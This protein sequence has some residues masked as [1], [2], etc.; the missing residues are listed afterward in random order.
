MARYRDL[1][2]LF[3]WAPA[4]AISNASCVSPLARGPPHARLA[5]IISSL[6]IYCPTKVTRQ[7]QQTFPFRAWGGARRR[8]ARKRD[9]RTGM[10]HRARPEHK[11]HHPVHVTLR[12]VRRLASMR[13]QIVFLE[14]RKAI[15]RTARAWFRIVHF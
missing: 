14:V 15:S 11:K 8:T 7:A 3:A 9:P 13:K 4:L 1:F 2:G 12:A 5:S 10:P 6:H